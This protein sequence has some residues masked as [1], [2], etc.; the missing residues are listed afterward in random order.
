MKATMTVIM[1]F[2]KNAK[3][4]GEK[5]LISAKKKKIDYKK[6][7]DYNYT[8][9]EEKGAKLKLYQET[10]KFIAEIKGYW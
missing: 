4:R 1:M 8:F 10:K 6:L 2:T 9:D 5:N 7:D 3:M